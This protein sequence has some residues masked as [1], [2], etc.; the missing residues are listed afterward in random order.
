MKRKT[1]QY[2]TISNVGEK[3]HVGEKCQ[4]FVPDPLPPEPELLVDGQRREDRMEAL[5]G[6]SDN[7]A[8]QKTESER[9]Q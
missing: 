6:W 7:P 1:G 4:A 8:A 3:C 5:C 2:V 9:I